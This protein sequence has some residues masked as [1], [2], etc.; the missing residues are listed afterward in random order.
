MIYG[1]SQ[2]TDRVDVGWWLDSLIR[3]CLEGRLGWRNGQFDRG[4]HDAAE[5]SS[6]VGIHRR[7]TPDMGRVE[8]T[9]DDQR[10]KQRDERLKT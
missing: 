3:I 8:G 9:R 10:E 6:M 5:R 4:L 2:R 1:A 7:G